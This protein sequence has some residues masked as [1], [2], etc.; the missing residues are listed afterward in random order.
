MGSTPT[1]LGRYEL[2]EVLGRGAMGTVYRAYDSVL[3]RTLA[4]KTYH[5]YLA[6]RDSV[7]LRF[8]REVKTTSKLGHPHIVVVY[9][10]GFEGE[11]PFIAMELVE[12]LTLDAL[13]ARGRLP[14]EEAT[15]ILLA[16]CDAMAYAHGKGVIHRDLKPANILMARNRHPKIS[17]F[18]LAKVA[19]SASGGLTTAPI[20][21]P[22]FMAPE[23][24]L[25]QP[26][27]R[28][29][30][31][32]ALGVLAYLMLTGKRP[33]TNDSVPAAMYAI[34]HGTPPPASEV[35]PELPRA[36][37]AF[38]ARAL[39]KRPEERTPDVTAFAS[40]LVAA[41][42]TRLTAPAPRERK[43]SRRAIGAAALPAVVAIGWLMVQA[44]E[45][46]PPPTVQP[47]TAEADELVGVSAAA[48][49][50]AAVEPAEEASAVEVPVA[51]VPVAEA[52]PAEPPMQLAS[53]P[54]IPPAA[55]KPA[56]PSE[57]RRLRDVPIP[58]AA[59]GAASIE[60]ASVPPGAEISVDGRSRGRTPQRVT[61]LASGS[62]RVVVEKAGYAP[63]ERTVDLA[64]KSNHQLALT[65][66]PSS[67]ALSIVS[68]PPGAEV[69]LNGESRGRTPVRIGDLAAGAHDVS[70][71]IPGHE[72]YHKRMSLK[73]GERRELR[74][75]V[76]R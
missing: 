45:L 59:A 18:G 2:R 56:Q 42:H 30:D 58:V 14:V 76:E 26:T 7:R 48:I 38:F 29:A 43:W 36:L 21:T 41:L 46:V 33:F 62:H 40:E 66:L 25:G 31:V 55:A 74:V 71:E 35:A 28:R 72:P 47:A 61:G 57:R 34:V 32:F 75:G 39:A 15:R 49:V 8:E 69:H 1:R 11:Q 50:P 52:A 22:T 53:V 44:P 67:A 3:E 16:I 64:R 6:S 24:I 27:G 5:P 13:L 68:D 65:L 10:G 9:D 51:E 73:P 19:D 17:D 4:V 60:V 70:V 54:P 37:D 12:G 23:Q 63:Y 20:G